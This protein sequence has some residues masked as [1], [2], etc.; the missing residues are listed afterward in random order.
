VLRYLLIGALLWVAWRA[1]SRT[2]WLAALRGE[3]ERKRLPGRAPHEVL[4]VA[5]DAPVEEAKR[6]YH[7]LVRQ[8]HPDKTE[9][10]SPELKRLAESR[11]AEL[12]EAFDAFKRSRRE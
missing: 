9:G 6:A 11:T 1:V 5:R 2:S 12:N 8:V 4:G 3:P 7:A 10:L